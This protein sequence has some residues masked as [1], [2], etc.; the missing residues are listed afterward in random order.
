M[1]LPP[2]DRI[3]FLCLLSVA[4]SEI[5]ILKNPSCPISK[6]KKQTK[7]NNLTLKVVND[8]CFKKDII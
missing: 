6:K 5:F 2:T 3:V 8:D 4:C 1:N 7:K